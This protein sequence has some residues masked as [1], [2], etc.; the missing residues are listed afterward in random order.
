ME[1]DKLDL[2]LLLNS[3][4]SDLAKGVDVLYTSTSNQL[5]AL[6]CYIKVLT[7]ILDEIIKLK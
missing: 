3:K 6:D 2:L 4:V 1:R 7:L 5:V